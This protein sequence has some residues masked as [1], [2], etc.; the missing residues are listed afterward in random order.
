MRLLVLDANA[1]DASRVLALLDGHPADRRLVFGGAAE[2]LATYA[3]A[4][5]QTQD[6]A[7]LDAVAAY[8]LEAKAGDPPERPAA[9]VALNDLLAVHDQG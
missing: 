2:A 7:F 4:R 9:P 1:T 3:M 6:D 8:V 5:R